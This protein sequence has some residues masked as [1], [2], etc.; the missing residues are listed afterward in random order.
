MSFSKKEYPPEYLAMIRQFRLIDDTFFA[1]C[2]DD[3]IKSME[4]ILK[5]ILGRNDIK[6]ESVVTQRSAQNLYG[7]GVRFDVL[8]YDITHKRIFNCEIQRVAEGAIPLRARVNSSLIDQR[9]LAKGTDFQDVPET[10]VIFI[11]EK[12]VFRDG[13]PIYHIERVIQETGKPFGDNAHII[14]V[15]GEVR[16]DTPLGRLMQDFF[17][18]DVQKIHNE[19][20]ANRVD[21]FKSNEK[22]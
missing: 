21:F 14:Y 13:L 12:D 1:A 22:G 10:F 9:E 11:M 6:V 4:A 20:L 7:R 18:P 17:E 2:L 3:D 16:D 5:P 8:A 15:N 19:A